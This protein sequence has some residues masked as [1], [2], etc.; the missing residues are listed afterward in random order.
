VIFFYG[1]RN[2]NHVRYSVFKKSL[3]VPVRLVMEEAG[4]ADGEERAAPGSIPDSIPA[5][6]KQINVGTFHCVVRSA[7]G[8]T[9]PVSWTCVPQM[10]IVGYI[11]TPG[12][13]S[14]CKE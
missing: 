14:G 5:P 3:L 7:V 13:D 1:G 6:P 2:W 9:L 10:L 11:S 8:R 4:R 12:R